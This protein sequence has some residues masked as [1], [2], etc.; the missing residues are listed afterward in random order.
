MPKFSKCWQ[1]VREGRV[2]LGEE[3]DGSCVKSELYGHRDLRCRWMVG[4][5]DGL[6]CLSK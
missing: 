3:D 5:D 4:V 1:V 2:V 6:E